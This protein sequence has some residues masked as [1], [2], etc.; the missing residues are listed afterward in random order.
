MTI[1]IEPCT[2]QDINNLQKISYE[3]F[4]DTFENQNSPENMKAY[5]EKAFNKTQLKKEL[6]NP[7]SCFFFLHYY[8]KVAGYLKL[9]IGKAQTEDMGKE[10]LEIERIYIKSNFQKKG[11]GSVLLNKALEIAEDLNKEK[12]WLGVWEKNI[13]AIDFYSK[14][15]FIQ[16][17]KHSFFMGDDE[18]TDYVMTKEIK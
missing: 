14:S 12:I 17:G 5:L 13:N 11:L 10:A 7:S 3:T 15:G 1:I 4:N 18:Q 16:T 8:D 9:N 2:A 6:S